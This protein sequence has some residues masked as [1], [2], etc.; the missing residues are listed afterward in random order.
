MRDIASRIFRVDEVPNLSVSVVIAAYNAE[1]TIA[2]AIRS[3][4]SQQS[5]NVQ[6]IVCDDC[7]TDNTRR[8]VEDFNDPR[9][10][11]LQNN[12]NLG[13]GPSRDRAIACAEEPWI[14]IVD[15]DDI[16]ESSRL[17]RLVNAAVST[18]C[19]LVF[20]DTLLSHDTLAG[21]VPWKPLHGSDAFGGHGR[22]PR[23][24]RVEDY[25]MSERLLIHPVIRTEI[26][27]SNL[28]L[29][30]DRRFGE[31]AEFY[32]R[33]GMAGAN[34]CYVPE[35]LYHYRLSLGSLTAQTQDRTLMRQCLEECA[36]WKGWWPSA[37]AAFE[38]K[39]ISLHFNE[40][41]YQLAQAARN[42]RFAEIVRLIASNPRLLVALPRRLAGQF[43][44]Q[45]HRIVHGGSGR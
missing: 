42:V 8:V 9:I 26:I 4:L 28:I 37:Q 18:G 12:N 45:I 16:V 27:R 35:P 21:L 6:V 38:E 22:M 34:F 14:A 7:S 29:H 25:I 44:Y 11:L 32:L 19:E 15:A 30:G 13:P 17:H 23:R 20:D 43:H 10:R 3:V 5:V 2:D 1:R 24:I 31:D 39:I 40:A 41:M 33:L 36:Q